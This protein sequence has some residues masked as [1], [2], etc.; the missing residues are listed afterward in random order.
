MT[1]TI[2]PGQLRRVERRMH[3]FAGAVLLAYLYAPF[4]AELEDI[5]RFVVFPALALTGIAMWQAA[6]VRRALRLVRHRGKEPNR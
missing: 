4:G 6:R 3:L 2:T 1:T 5:I